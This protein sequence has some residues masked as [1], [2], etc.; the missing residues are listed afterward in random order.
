MPEGLVLEP[1]LA[2]NT[3]SASIFEDRV[4]RP[5]QHTEGTDRHESKH[6]FLH[7][8]DSYGFC[9]S[10][11]ALVERIPLTRACDSQLNREALYSSF[12]PLQYSQQRTFEWIMRVLD[13]DTEERINLVLLFLVL[14]TFHVKVFL[15][16]ALSRQPHLG[17]LN[18]LT[19][20]VC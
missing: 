8:F 14:P 19:G 5:L 4:G 20:S 3:R 18:L 11:I 9:F 1:R 6:S 2:R 10:F 13:G 12:V 15:G 16:L 17:N 7:I